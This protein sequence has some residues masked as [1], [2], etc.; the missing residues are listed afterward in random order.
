MKGKTMGY[1]IWQRRR[2]LL[3]DFCERHQLST[4]HP[5]ALAAATW[6]MKTH[7]EDELLLENLL[8]DIADM[9]VFTKNSQHQ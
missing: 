3:D 9:G 1:G 5:A 4:Q 2:Q 6:L 8:V 7:S